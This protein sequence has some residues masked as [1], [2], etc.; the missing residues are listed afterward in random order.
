MQ[1]ELTPREHHSMKVGAYLAAC[2]FLSAIKHRGLEKTLEDMRCSANGW[3]T[4]AEDK[5]HSETMFSS[6]LDTLDEID[7]LGGKHY[8]GPV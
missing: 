2:T 3:K 6:L 7:E 5:E 1:E 8:E 4:Y